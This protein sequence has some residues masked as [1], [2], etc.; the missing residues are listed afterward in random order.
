MLSGEVL[1]LVAA[2]APSN[3]MHVRYSRLI[4]RAKSR[5]SGEDGCWK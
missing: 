3:E 2:K 4:M 5:A 1:E